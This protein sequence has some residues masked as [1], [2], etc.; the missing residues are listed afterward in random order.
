MRGPRVL[1]KVTRE[2]N[3]HEE[4]RVKIFSPSNNAE[5]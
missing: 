4:S 3:M 1:L 5:H 2:Y